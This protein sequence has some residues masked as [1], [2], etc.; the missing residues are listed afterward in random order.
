MLHLN[1]N[2]FTFNNLTQLLGHVMN[3]RYLANKCFLGCNPRDKVV[4]LY[5]CGN[6][7]DWEE[8]FIRPALGTPQVNVSIPGLFVQG[9]IWVNLQPRVCGGA[10]KVQSDGY[11]RADSSSGTTFGM[12]SDFTSWNQPM[13]INF[14]DPIS[15]L[16]LGAPSTFNGNDKRAKMLPVNLADSTA[17]KATGWMTAW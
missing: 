11:L 2:D 9:P 6:A 1:T 8:I 13:W 10:F 3:L 14:F 15:S 7:Q 4:G 16:V 5:T 12:I 17:R